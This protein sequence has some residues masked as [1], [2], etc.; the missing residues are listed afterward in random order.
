MKKKERL[1]KILT[2]KRI[3]KFNKTLLQSMISGNISNQ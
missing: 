2:I 3:N 1:K